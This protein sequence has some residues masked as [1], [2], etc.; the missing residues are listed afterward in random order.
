MR[1]T[2]T[3]EA[4]K[5]HIDNYRSDGL[6]KQI[7]HRYQSSYY[8]VAFIIENVP[9]NSKVLDVGCNGGTLGVP[10]IQQKNCHVNGIDIVQ[11]LVDKAKKRG[12]FAEQGQAEDLS[13]FKD[14]TFDVVICAEVLEHL[15]DPFKAVEEAHRVLKKGGLYITTVPAPKGGM[16]DDS[17][18]DYH[19]QNFSM[20]MLDTMMHNFFERGKV[21]ASG[22]PYIPEYC[23][24]N[25]FDPNVVQWIATIAEK[26]I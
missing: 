12:V 2:S 5:A 19:Q 20:E 18:G 10:L 25:N 24:A 11:E 23:R 3:K 4:Q 13:R 26:T 14:E 8:R 15:Y 9:E 21:T 16:A 17:L 6:G 7:G 22:I 1:Y